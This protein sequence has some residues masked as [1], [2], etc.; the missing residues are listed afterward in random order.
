MKHSIELFLPINMPHDISNIF[1]PI[2]YTPHW[3]GPT[4]KEKRYIY[5]NAIILIIYKFRV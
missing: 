5:F 2:L 1:L 4:L 3:R